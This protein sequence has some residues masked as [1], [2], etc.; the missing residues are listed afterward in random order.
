MIKNQKH[1]KKSVKYFFSIN[2]ITISALV[3]CM[4][5]PDAFCLEPPQPGEIERYK[6]DGSFDHRISFVRFL[7]NHRFHPSLIQQKKPGVRL[8]QQDP[9][10]ALFPYNTGLPSQGT[11][12]IFILLIEFPNFPHATDVA[13]FN[14]KIFGD[15]DQS[16]Y[17]YE[18]LTNYYDRSS[19]GSLTIQGDVLGWYQAQHRRGWYSFGLFTRHSING[20]KKL[21]K[22]ALLSY[23]GSHD[24]AQY[25]N[26]GDG[27]IDY[28]AVIWT[29][30]DTGWG[31]VWWGWAQHDGA[32]WAGD[33]FTIDG[34]RLGVFSWQWEINE[35]LEEYVYSP[36]TIIHETGHALGLPD[37]YDYDE[38]QG[39][40]GGVGGLDMMDGN[41][42]DHNCFSKWMLGW[43]TP[44]VITGGSKAPAL[45]PSSE[46][47]DCIAIMPSQ[48]GSID[49]FSEYFLV[50]HRSATENDYNIP[51]NG[52]LIWHV[53]AVL[54]MEGT[55]FAFDNSYT[56]HKLLRLMEADG[57]EEIE[58]LSWQE[59]YFDPDDFYV[60]GTEF[61]PE[62]IPN[63]SDYTGTDTGVSVTN[64]SADEQ[65]NTMS[66]DFEIVE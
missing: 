55:D 41:E 64:I 15:G 36:V 20:I 45:N 40:G 66:A 58:N 22:E 42:F 30:P 12:K 60:P 19:Y 17:P 14:R 6:R 61:T 3:L 8:L 43:I 39:P 11:P 27:T 25:D 49:P 1:N 23:D 31:S 38:N 33:P 10:E 46:M 18:S 13:V 63:S 24:F 4:L 26:D 48:T 9:T 28:F 2:Y 56:D 21:I 50:Q 65:S 47:Q 16:E 7:N 62:S 57:R 54:N 5:P 51:N 52:Y 34:K 44:D 29:G 59:S 32:L 35:R 53:D 37:Y